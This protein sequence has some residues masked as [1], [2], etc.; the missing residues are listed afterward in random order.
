MST[1][2][3]TER[4]P[5]VSRIYRATKR[6]NRQTGIKGQWNARKHGGS[7]RLVWRKIHIGIDQDTLEVRAAE[8]TGNNIGDALM[9]PKFLNQ[10][11]S[12]QDIGS[13]TADGAYETRKC[14]EAIAARDAHAVVPLRKNAKLWKPTST[15]AIARNDAVNAQRYLGR[16]LWRRLG[17]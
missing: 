17:Y 7:K 6:P 10:V 16:T 15:G 1:S 9:L 12:D 2:A 3:D 4:E 11:P 5:A 13:V 14:Q 8:V